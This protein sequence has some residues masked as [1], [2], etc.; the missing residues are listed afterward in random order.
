MTTA[1][2]FYDGRGRH[3]VWLGSIQAVLLVRKV[4][5]TGCDPALVPRT[6]AANAPWLTTTSYSPLRSSLVPKDQ[7]CPD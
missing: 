2:D 7:R 3:V 4:S 5:A 1:A 6:S